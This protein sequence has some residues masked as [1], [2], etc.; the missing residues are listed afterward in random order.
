MLQVKI[1]FLVRQLHNYIYLTHSVYNISSPLLINNIIFNGFQQITDVMDQFWLCLANIPLRWTE[2]CGDHF[3]QWNIWR[4]QFIK[5]IV[6]KIKL[7][8]NYKTGFISQE[9][10]KVETLTQKNYRVPDGIRT[11][12][13]SWSSQML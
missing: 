9:I 4:F 1:K 12:D 2:F 3:R 5:Y 13:P 8:F 7:L 6:L 11:H 10:F